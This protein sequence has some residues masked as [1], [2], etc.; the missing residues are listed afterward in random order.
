VDDQ[1]E[2]MD[3][4]EEEEQDEEEISFFEMIIESTQREKNILR[5]HHSLLELFDVH[6]VEP[7]HEPNFDSPEGLD[8]LI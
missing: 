5:D 8:A 1:E 6:L 2:E 3:E 7:Y 4:L